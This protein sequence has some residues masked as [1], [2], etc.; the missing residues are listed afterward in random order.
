MQAVSADEKGS[1]ASEK[2]NWMNERTLR[3]TE[4]SHMSSWVVYDRK[5]SAEVV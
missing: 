4:V 2:T 1:S 3:E 5:K